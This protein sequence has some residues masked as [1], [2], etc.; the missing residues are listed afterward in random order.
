M[1]DFQIGRFVN[2][3]I[4]ELNS[5]FGTKIIKSFKII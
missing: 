4:K 2:G 1:I 3:K 5:K